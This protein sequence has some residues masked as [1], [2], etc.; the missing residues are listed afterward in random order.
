ML[1]ILLFLAF[2][3]PPKVFKFQPCSS[4][5]TSKCC[6]LVLTSM[7]FHS[8]HSQYSYIHSTS[9]EQLDCLQLSANTN[10]ASRNIL[11]HFHLWFYKERTHLS[12]GIAYL[13]W[14]GIASLLQV[15]YF[16]LY[17]NQQ[18]LSIPMFPL[19]T[20][21]Q[22]YQLIFYLSDRSL[23]IFIVILICIHLISNDFEYHFVRLS[24]PQVFSLMTCLCIYS[25]IIF[26][27]G[28]TSASYLFV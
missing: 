2:F 9:K 8:M 25:G 14:L 5:Y 16:I 10:N 6:L 24:V 7:D 19:P 22:Q 13:I 23:G 18:C 11:I 3:I 27:L 21:T 20:N 26:L 12:Y 1:Q 4:K 15:V 17:S 28:F